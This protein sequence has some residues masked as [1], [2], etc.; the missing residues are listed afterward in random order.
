[1]TE[2]RRWRGCRG[3]YGGVLG[4]DR[5]GWCR[6]VVAR[7][8]AAWAGWVTGY[9][10]Q[11]LRRVKSFGASTIPWGRW[12]PVDSQKLKG[13]PKRLSRI[14]QRESETTSKVRVNR[15]ENSK[16]SLLTLISFVCAIPISLRFPRA[17][18][19]YS[20]QQTDDCRTI[21]MPKTRIQNARFIRRPGN[22][23]VERRWNG[24]FQSGSM[25]FATNQKSG[26]LT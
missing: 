3:G 12:H 13:V 6:G 20:I 14:G 1:M 2:R 17:L 18:H 23:F 26:G 22:T 19:R 5:S 24:V 7:V 15:P 8:L 11:S 4:G 9:V 16:S 21:K 25:R 10:R